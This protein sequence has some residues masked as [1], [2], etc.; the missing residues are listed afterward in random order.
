[1]SEILFNSRNVFVRGVFAHIILN[2]TNSRSLRNVSDRLI[3]V[4][5]ALIGQFH[6]LLANLISAVCPTRVAYD[7]QNHRK[8]QRTHFAIS[9]GCCV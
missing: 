8:I 9:T 7:K 1:M 6:G 5:F 2:D 3:A 4:S